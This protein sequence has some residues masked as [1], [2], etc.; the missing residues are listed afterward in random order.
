M[1]IDRI[2][3][4]TIRTPIAPRRGVSMAWTDAHEYLLVR[5]GDDDGVIGWGETYLVSGVV[6]AIEQVAPLV[7]G[8]RPDDRRTVVL[9]V[10]RAAEHAY[11]SSALAI[12]LEDLHAKTFG[13]P[14]ASFFGGSVRSAVRPYAASLGYVDG[15]DP[16]RTWPDELALAIDSGFNALKLRIGRWPVEHEAPILQRVASSAPSGFMVMVDAN[17]GYSL[18]E[19]VTMGR[20]LEDLG[21]HWFEEPMP[22]WGGYAAYERL[23]S[24]LDIAVAGGELL[25]GR[26]AAA[27]LLRRAAVDII[28]PDPVICGGIAETV[29]VGELAALDAVPCVPHTSNGPIGVAAALQ[30]LAVIPGPSEAPSQQLP[31]LELGLDPN[32]WHDGVLASGT[33]TSRSGRV[34][35]PNA[36]GLGVE[37]DKEFVR[38][39]SDSHLTIT[40]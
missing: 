38:A 25:D 31:M 5:L 40:R 24:T 11:A 32:P 37:V 35:I 13:I 6:S 14:V 29:F 15:E 10:R 17:G 18:P 20:K 8:R 22:Q 39:R 7:L 28:Q 4:F 9:A 3:L 23:A 21:I 33:I 27:S 26:S 34:E 12:A 19:A 30:A 36:P 16:A 1:A 2:D